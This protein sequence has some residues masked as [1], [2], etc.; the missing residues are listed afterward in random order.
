M[1]MNVELPKTNF[2]TSCITKEGK[3]IRP[4]VGRD[5]GNHEF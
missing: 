1:S 3:G 5:V 2:E 4:S